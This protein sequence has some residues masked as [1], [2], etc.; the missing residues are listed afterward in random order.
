MTL[1]PVKFSG[2]ACQF[3]HRSIMKEIGLH[4]DLEFNELHKMQQD[5]SFDVIFCYLCNEHKPEPIPIY[6]NPQVWMHHLRGAHP[7]QVPGIEPLLVG[8]KEPRVMFVDADTTKEES[9]ITQ[10]VSQYANV[11]QQP[12]IRDRSQR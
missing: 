6:V 12:L 11:E 1:L 5:Y 8:Q 9:D 7:L 4:G 10:Y 2:F 3:I